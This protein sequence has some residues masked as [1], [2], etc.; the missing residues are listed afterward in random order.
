MESSRTLCLINETNEEGGCAEI[1]ESFLRCCAAEAFSAPF[2]KLI[3]L[4]LLA[5]RLKRTRRVI[6]EGVKLHIGEE[7]ISV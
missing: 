5:K 4:I 7:V 2:D 6:R 3:R 1:S